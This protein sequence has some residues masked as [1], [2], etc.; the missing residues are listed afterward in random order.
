MLLNLANLALLET[1]TRDLMANHSDLL[2]SYAVWT[3][4]PKNIEANTI[5]E[6]FICCIFRLPSNRI[7]SPFQIKSSHE[8][9]KKNLISTV[10]PVAF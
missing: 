4:L 10:V 7:R 8:R 2:K 6:Y 9:I 1:T 3:F 5:V